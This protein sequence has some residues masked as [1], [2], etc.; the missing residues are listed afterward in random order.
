MTLNNN[1]LKNLPFPYFV[2]DRNFKILFQSNNSLEVFSSEKNF[3]ELADESSRKKLRNFLSDTNDSHYLNICMLKKNLKAFSV[4]LYKLRSDNEF[5]LF[6]FPFE[7]DSD[8]RLQVDSL[9]QKYDNEMNIQVIKEVLPN[10][11]YFA[12]I[13]K[14]AAGIV[15][16]IRNP[17]T[18]VK[19]F[20]QLLKPYLSEIGKEFYADVA[21]EEI[22]RTNEIIFEFL[23]N[24]KPN[25]RM[26]QPAHLNKIIKDVVILY[27]SEAI[28]RN[29][30][31]T[32]EY[33]EKDTVLQIEEKQLKHI[34]TNILNNAIEALNNREN[35]VQGFIHIAAESFEN[36]SVITIEDNGCGMSKET[37]ERLFLPFYSTKEN[38][39]GI[40]MP[41]CKKIIEDNGGQI[42][43]S[44]T[45]N[46]G[47]SIKI[48]LPV[49]REA[50]LTS[51]V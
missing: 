30:K 12:S 27:K 51:I 46:I 13:G 25:D 45:E 1:L 39:T 48:V 10:N 7:L 15:H 22:N 4:R 21:L 41:L 38:G 40:G 44:S 35:C 32:V 23:N 11:D 17:L 28:L 3:L 31:I 50:K 49:V 9:C 19:G 24:A 6:C 16:E 20:I 43:I 37:L 2:I 29:I 18:A 14:L 36:H 47:T 34:L 5:H 26:K 8:D 33:D 42:E